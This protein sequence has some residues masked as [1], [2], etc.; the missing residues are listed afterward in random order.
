M[1]KEIKHITRSLCVIRL[2]RVSRPSFLVTNEKSGFAVKYDDA[3]LL[4]NACL[5]SR[6][7]L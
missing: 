3:C 5:A 7:Q 6:K 2:K 4:A 1:E